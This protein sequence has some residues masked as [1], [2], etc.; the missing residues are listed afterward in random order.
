MDGRC[1]A[2]YTR[3]FG[4]EVGIPFV[5]TGHT[6]RGR[7]ELTAVN[8]Y[9]GNQGNKIGLPRE[10]QREEFRAVTRVLQDVGIQSGLGLRRGPQ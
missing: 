3:V 1:I 8:E 6:G 5:M 2:Q 9:R 10:Y 7:E 4:A